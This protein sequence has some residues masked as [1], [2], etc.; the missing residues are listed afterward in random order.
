MGPENPIKPST[1]SQCTDVDLAELCSLK[2]KIRG[3]SRPVRYCL[4]VLLH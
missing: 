4:C 1:P 3:G 2:D